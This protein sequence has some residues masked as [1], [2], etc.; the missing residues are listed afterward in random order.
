MTD[1]AAVEYAQAEQARLKTG[2]DVARLIELEPT[3][4]QYRAEWIDNPRTDRA[5]LTEKLARLVGK[6]RWIRESDAVTLAKDCPPGRDK[7]LWGAEVLDRLFGRGG[8]RSGEATL[9][10]EA[11]PAAALCYVTAP[12]EA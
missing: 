12:Q 3:L 4:N 10:G 7:G 11:A 8:P 5:L 6:P 2:V 1:L 9:Y